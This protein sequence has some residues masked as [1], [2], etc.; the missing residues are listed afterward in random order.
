MSMEA[1]RSTGQQAQ[2][3]FEREKDA[4]MTLMLENGNIV[5]GYIVKDDTMHYWRGNEERHIA[6]FRKAL[7]EQLAKRTRD[8]GA[9]GQAFERACHGTGSGSLEC[10]AAKGGRRYAIAWRSVE[11]EDGVRAV[12]GFLMKVGG[13]PGLQDRQGDLR[14]LAKVCPMEEIGR[15]VDDA[16]S[17][18]APGEK[19]VL[20]RLAI[21]NFD[22][23]HE[24]L[25][26]GNLDRYM[27]GTIG[28]ILADFRAQDVV[29]RTA[30]NE[31][32]VFIRGTLSI[33]VIERRAQRIV[34]FFL[35][36]NLR[37]HAPK[38]EVSCRMGVAIGSRHS[39]YRKLYD[40][41]GEAL[42]RAWLNHFRMYGDWKA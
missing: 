33:D 7:Q 41:A 4:L 25:G 21:Q 17:Y 15:I 39:D 10:A 18:L 1:K 32:I 3:R 35:R 34:D 28:A 22:Q 24:I 2:R 40:Q 36:V 12:Y 23:E 37:D 6:G 14:E 30:V 9:V 38:N 19:G 16:L 5:F 26:A 20:F 27:Q 13:A 29:Q 8:A 42:P 31:V 11:Q